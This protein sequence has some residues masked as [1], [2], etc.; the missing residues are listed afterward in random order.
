MTNS[1]CTRWAIGLVKW[2][3]KEISH[4]PRRQRHYQ[5]RGIMTVRYIGQ[6]IKKCLFECD[7]DMCE[8]DWCLSA[9]GARDSSAP[10]SLAVL[11]AAPALSLISRLF[12]ELSAD[13]ATSAWRNVN[14]KAVNALLIWLIIFIFHSVILHGDTSFMLVSV[15]LFL[16]AVKLPWLFLSVA[17]CWL[18]IT[19]HLLHTFQSGETS[20]WKKISVYYSR[21]YVTTEACQAVDVAQLLRWIPPL[22]L[23]TSGGGSWWL[24]WDGW[25][26]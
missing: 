5:Q 3:N 25:G 21:W 6:I 7:G 18:Q 23:D 9:R 10:A 14:M 15:V 24:C 20:A 8:R 26:D 11:S 22:S 17:T 2:G 4:V 19:F 1:E 13:Y 12:Y 16:T